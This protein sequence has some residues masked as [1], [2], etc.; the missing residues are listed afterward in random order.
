MANLES[1]K[2][3]VLNIESILDAMNEAILITDSEG[4][5]CFLND[6]YCRMRGVSKE[7]A[8]GK[9]IEEVRPGPLVIPRV[10]NTGR[11]IQ[12]IRKKK[13]EDEYISDVIP[14]LENGRVLGVVSVSRN[15]K[16]VSNLIES[17]KNSNTSITK[18]ED[19]DYAAREIFA[20]IVCASP[21]FHRIIETVKRIAQTEST[22]LI[23]GETG[24]GKELIAR[25]IHAASARNKGY[26]VAVNCAAIPADLLESE[27]FGYEPGAFTG[28]NKQG[29]IGLLELADKGTIF[30][31]EIGDMNAYLQAKL[32]RVLEERVVRRIGGTKEKKIDIR[33]IAATN[34]DLEELMARGLFRE[35]LFYRLN[36][37]P[38]Y[39]P[40]LRERKEDIIAIAQYYLGQLNNK[41]RRNLKFSWQALKELVNYP[42]PGNVRELKNAVEYAVNVVEGE[43]I[44]PD[45]FPFSRNGKNG[46]KI[47]MGANPDEETRRLRFLKKEVE[48]QAILEQLK[49]YGHSTEGKRR[50]AEA[51]GISLATLYRKLKAGDNH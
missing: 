51:L 49:I 45:C 4:R 50:A 28:A 13:G 37:V 10:L 44:P 30:L 24:T 48:V 5:I 11:A 36:V 20:N 27:L 31:D 39:L 29:K 43:L 32:L 17:Y 12:G 34:K 15:V 41:Y 38:I 22:V 35:D 1:S 7:E 6:A 18:Y 9:R 16:E 47:K 3:G 42:W 19:Q 40:P 14:I 25:A 2:I 46:F 23:R 8:I 33:I 26:F 21:S